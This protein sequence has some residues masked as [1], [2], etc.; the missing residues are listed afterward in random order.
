MYWS[1]KPEVR[2]VDPK[3]TR[4]AVV[5]L[6]AIATAGSLSPRALA[7][8]GGRQLA[9]AAQPAPAVE[10]ERLLAPAISVLRTLVGTWRFEIRF[11]GNFDG[12]P[13][14]A[15]TRV[16]KQLFDSLRLEWTEQL[17][18]STLGGGRGLVAFDP[19]SGRF[20][21]TAMYSSGATPELMAGTPDEAEPLVTFR[22]LA[23]GAQPFAL[24]VVDRDHF[25]VTAL[26]HTWRALFTRRSP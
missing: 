13:D 9:R 11:A 7:A 1:G 23:A 2:T 6:F 15:G 16:V 5:A 18:N 24:S 17:D 10:S 3:H 12:P 26:D 8:Q 4:T 19:A 22:P 25:L 14:A 20:Y 21:A